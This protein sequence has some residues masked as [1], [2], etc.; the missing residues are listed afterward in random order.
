[1]NEAFIRKNRV[2]ALLALRRN[3]EAREDLEW[4]HNNNVAEA[5]DLM[6]LAKI[7]LLLSDS[8]K[9]I[10]VLRDCIERF[11]NVADAYTTLSHIYLL[12]GKRA[13]CFE[14]ATKARQRFPDDP[15]VLSYLWFIS[16]P[17]GE[18]LRPEVAEVFKAFLPGGMFADQS[19]FIPITMEDLVKLASSQPSQMMAPEVLYKT[20]QI[21]WMMLSVMRNVPAFLAHQQAKVRGEMRYV[22][23]GDQLK[24][25]EYL[26]QNRPR[27]VV[28]D[29][30]ALLTLWSLF[31]DQLL[32]YLSHY[33]DSVLLP[34][35]LR[36]ILLTEQEQMATIGQPA[37]YRA[38]SAVQSAL[39][40]YSNKVTVHPLIVPEKG[41]DVS[42]RH[43]EIAVAERDHLIYLD[44][45]SQSNE[46]LSQVPTE[47]LAVLA[48]VLYQA[49]EIDLLIAQEFKR[50][51]RPATQEESELGTN[52]E[53]DS[54]IVVNIST[55]VTWAMRHE[56]DPILIYFEHV[57]IAEPALDRLN[58]EIAA[59]DFHQ[60]ALKDIRT[61]RRLLHRGEKDDLIMFETIPDEERLVRRLVEA[62]RVSEQPS[63]SLQGDSNHP[64]VLQYLDDYLDE[65]F[66]VAAQ[67]NIPIWTDDR[68]TKVLI[69]E[70]CQP[71]YRFGTDTFLSF[72]HQYP[73]VAEPLS[74]E[75]YYAYYNRLVKWRYSFLPINTHQIMWYL[76]EGRDP[77]SKPLVSL[78]RHYRECI[79]EFWNLS[80]TQNVGEQLGI[81]LFG[82][83]RQ[84]LT[85]M[86]REL[87]DNNFSPKVAAEIFAL[88]DLSR[89]VP[90]THIG[91]EPFLVS[92]ILLSAVIAE[93]ISKGTISLRSSEQTL[94]YYHWLNTV[95]LQSGVPFEVME[96]AWYQLIRSPIA[97][98]EE[99]QT[100][101]ERLEA[102]AF[103]ESLLD[104]MPER[105]IQYLLSTDIGPRLQEGFGL[106][107]H[108][109][110]YFQFGNGAEEK[111][112]I[113]LSTVEWQQDYAQALTKY[114]QEPVTE[115]ISVG[116]VTLKARSIAPGSVFLVVE[117]LPTEIYNQYPDARGTREYFC[118]LFGFTGPEAIHREA[119][120]DIGLR[121]LKR[122]NASIDNWLSQKAALLM[123]DDLGTSTGHR[124]R[125]YLLGV[126]SVACEYLM[127]A[128]QLG[129]RNVLHLLAF[130][131]P[132]VIRDWLAMPS[133]DWTSE[134]GLIQWAKGL[135]APSFE[136]LNPAKVTDF[137]EQFGHSIFPDAPIVRQYILTALQNCTSTTE[138]QDLI[139][140]LLSLAKA[141]PSLALKANIALVLYA[142]LA[143]DETIK[144]DNN[145]ACVISERMTSFISEV[146]QG[147]A[148][149]G[150]QAGLANALEPVLCEWLYY[151][152]VSS[153]GSSDLSPLELAYLAY[154][155][156][157]H[158]IDALVVRGKIDNEVAQEVIDQL[159]TKLKFQRI[160]MG[161]ES[162]PKGFFRPVWCTYLN[163]AASYLLEGL[164]TE[165]LPAPEFRSN[166]RIKEVALACG[167]HHRR[168]QT[169]CFSEPLDLSWLDTTLATDIGRA[170][171]AILGSLDEDELEIWPE[172]EF[173]QLQFA[174][175]PVSTD[176]LHTVIKGIPE[177]ASGEQILQILSWLFQGRNQS[178]PAWFA[179]VQNLFDPEILKAFRR[180]EGCYGELLWRAGDLLLHPPRNCPSELM[181][182]IADLLF[183]ISTTEDAAALVNI[184]A[185]ALSQ[186]LA[187][188]LDVQ[189]VC[190]WLQ[191]VVE[192][193]AI[194]VPMSRIALRP[195]ILRWPHYNTK[196][197]EPLFEM[198]M[199]IADLP[200]YRGL[201]EFAR[202]ARHRRV[203]RAQ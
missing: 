159:I 70:N 97:M 179:R 137:M 66:G 53:R 170:S 124:L 63:K 77:E 158:I 195:F 83:Y 114:L 2:H 39:R 140:S 98:L 10:N 119:L 163:Y 129:P 133:F 106:K 149:D 144:L 56:I 102:V 68:F 138:Q 201:W 172:E 24:D 148:S 192:S 131:E 143:D 157:S 58:A 49:G 57:H 79:V 65:L 19:P 75:A 109:Q 175:T 95:V 8:D 37:R 188:G 16:H 88:L 5:P 100:E 183:E 41:W 78:L 160:G 108:N 44:E 93:R 87:Y 196:I 128:A 80:A 54:Q 55:L 74:V 185:D 50:Y 136:D 116:L 199:K 81:R 23:D 52:L 13:E 1:M 190:Q 99:A 29:Y 123:L 85:T 43:T 162:Q 155:G 48:E 193:D 174:V 173:N 104:A 62:Q 30:T 135:S 110:V 181:D 28:L 120:W 122:H 141:G 176:S 194:D 90:H 197:R 112:D 151:A 182:A 105:V 76:R 42:G 125:Q 127:Q 60:Q 178:G 25:V 15:N 126:R 92:V 198:L 164:I 130:L 200:I 117:S 187:L 7:Y 36:G 27:E 12:A 71:V 73:G 146:L 20:G 150:A 94:Q 64:P 38:N 202:L 35:A 9:A 165:N 4:L 61:L 142:W 107:I 59:Y 45:Y 103:A 26:M 152:W 166:P 21:S 132:D 34:E 33:F 113:H 168:E 121:A 82:L 22:A 40:A 134:D 101:F 47:G 139:N 18:E 111:Q 17:T 72:A 147:Y 91:R 171:V 167:V 161:V 11:P 67:R 169:F 89:Y 203:I 69:F 86:L 96:E 153:P 51:A 186:F 154:V 177:L 115:A 156:A 184:Q 31:D 118:L 14:W 84:Q 145:P 180:F 6:A 189:L 3:T 191:D 46:S 32:S